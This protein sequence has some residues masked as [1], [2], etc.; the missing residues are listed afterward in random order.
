MNIFSFYMVFR[1][2]S[3][4]KQETARYSY[5]ANFFKWILV[6]NIISFLFHGSTQYIGIHKSGRPVI[7]QKNIHLNS[8][9]ETSEAVTEISFEV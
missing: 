3:H 9:S 4:E 2:L 6:M 8:Y 7:H 1:I 5:R